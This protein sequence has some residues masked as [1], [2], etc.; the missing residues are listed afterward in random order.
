M[1]DNITLEACQ[2]RP[3]EEDGTLLFDTFSGFELN[4]VT[5]PDQY[6]GVVS[7]PKRNIGAPWTQAYARLDT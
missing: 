4:M 5:I 6:V 7:S 3:V 2:P 1:Q